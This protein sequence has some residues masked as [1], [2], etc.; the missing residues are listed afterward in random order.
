MIEPGFVVMGGRDG[1]HLELHGFVARQIEGSSQ[2]T[3]CIR[4]I[5]R[6]L[7]SDKMHRPSDYCGCYLDAKLLFRFFA[8]VPQDPCD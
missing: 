1:L 3:L 8:H 6:S 5:F 7:G 4:V 2:P